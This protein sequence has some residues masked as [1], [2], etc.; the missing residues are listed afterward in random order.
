MS[1]GYSLKGLVK[2]L[3]HDPWKDHLDLV[4]DEH[5]DP[6]LDVLDI[7]LKDIEINFGKDSAL[8]LYSCAIEDFM[9]RDF[10]FEL[11]NVVDEYLRRRR[12]KE[13][14]KNQAYL[15]AVRASI[16]SLYEVIEVGPKTSIKLRDL[17]RGGNPVV[18]REVGSI[19]V[20][21]PGTQIAARIIPV[22]GK[23][24]LQTGMLPYA[25][26]ITEV[27]FA[28]L[29][30]ALGV[31]DEEKPLVVDDEELQA[32]A[33]LFTFVWMIDAFD[34]PVDQ[35]MIKLADQLAE[36]ELAEENAFKVLQKGAEL[37][38]ERLGLEGL[39]DEEIIEKL[40][41]NIEHVERERR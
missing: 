41:E 6:V 18:V 16:M 33:F 30:L 1:K 31:D 14:P 38:R 20:L 35:M 13:S 8:L 3:S 27:L 34:L 26:E 37:I 36:K 11:A 22:L 25:P 32:H 10:G 17:I 7:E 9:T 24:V 28:S 5:F 2:F 40:M 4:L 21:E 23:N 19:D 15:K 29:R 39:D 12:W